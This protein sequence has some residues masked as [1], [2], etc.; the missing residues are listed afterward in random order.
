MG[1]GRAL[2]E[3]TSKAKKPRE[4]RR[5][6][7]VHRCRL[8]ALGVPQEVVDGLNTKELRELL[9]YPE[10]TRKLYAGKKAV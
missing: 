10:K 6:E 7:K 2:E 1:S 9:K 5:R 8:L 3:L 4:R